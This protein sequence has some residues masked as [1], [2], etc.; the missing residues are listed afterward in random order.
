[1]RVT[2]GQFAQLHRVSKKT[3]RHYKEIGL[4]VPAETDSGNGYSFYK[5]AQHERMR[6]ILYL[7][8][9]RFSLEDIR[10]MLDAGAEQW[11]EPVQMQLAALQAEKQLLHEIRSEL[12]ALQARVG[13]GQ[14][15]YVPISASVPPA[16]VYRADTFELR[17][18]LFVVG[19]AA[20][21][22]YAKQAEKQRLIDELIG[23]FFGNEEA[24]LIAN[25]AVPAV[26]L[27]LVCECEADLSSGTYL[28]GVQV[29]APG[30]IPEGMRGYTLP[31]GLYARVSFR[32]G[33]RETL[34]GAAL[35]GAYGYLYDEWLPQSPYA[36]AETL[37]AE[38]Y[39]EERMELPVNPE[40][41]LWH[42][43]QRG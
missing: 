13:A 6:H 25:P 21:V 36:P 2:I 41:E 18:P 22:P 14:E 42:L 26:N 8:R 16:I 23:N 12:H 3:L 15:P 4:L 17:Q 20:R 7:R 34:T 38:I 10:V 9:L 24:G 37:T 11:I 5:E 33:D 39:R 43:L 31:A 35:E 40:M 32:A 19:R 28:M 1:M 27:G 29:R 30:E